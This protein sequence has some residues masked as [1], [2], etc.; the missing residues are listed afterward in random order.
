MAGSRALACWV[1]TLWRLLGEFEGLAS[2]GVQGVKRP[3]DG[4]KDAQVGDH[5]SALCPALLVASDA[6]GVR[7]AQGTQQ[8][9]WSPHL[10]NAGLLA[11]ALGSDRGTHCERE[12]W[13][14]QPLCSLQKDSAFWPRDIQAPEC[15]WTSFQAPQ[16][17]DS[18]LFKLRLPLAS[19]PTPPCA[20]PLQALAWGQP[21]PLASQGPRLSACPLSRKSVIQLD[22]AN[23]KKAMIVPAF[24]TLRYRLSFPK[25]K[26][27]LLSMLDMGTLFTFR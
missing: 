24:E 27:E 3:R 5:L 11:F 9:G 17:S 16:V 10:A 19:S 12:G 15:C 1:L 21:L 25:S 14:P 13:G 6:S 23:T 4:T 2:E 26:A 18:L 7:P 20:S 8:A 22:L